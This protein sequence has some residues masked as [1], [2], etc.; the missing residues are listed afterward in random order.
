G[1]GGS[2]VFIYNCPEQGLYEVGEVSKNN[3][4]NG[5]PYAIALKRCFDRVVLKNSKIAYSGIYSD[6]ESEEFTKRIDEETPTKE[7]PPKTTKKAP[8]Q[9]GEEIMIQDSQVNIIKN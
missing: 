2:L 5:Y 7:E 3:C 9:K 6:S 4:Q 1:Y 8:T